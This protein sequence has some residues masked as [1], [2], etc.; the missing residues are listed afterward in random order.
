A[1]LARRHGWRQIDQPLRIRRKAAH[2]LEGRRGVLLSN[3]D[4]PVQSRLDETLTAYVIDVEQIVVRLLCAERSGS[5][6]YKKRA[7]RL[8]VRG[9]RR[10]GHQ[11]LLGPPQGR[12]APAEHATGVDVDRA[13]QPLGFRYRRVALP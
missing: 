4:V 12:E 7:S 11:L 6:R 9:P 1:G 5:G 8:R 2:D 13:I 10:H 3:R